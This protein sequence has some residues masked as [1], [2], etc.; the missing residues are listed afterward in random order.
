MNTNSQKLYIKNNKI[1]HKNV[2][3]QKKFF[4]FKKLTYTKSTSFHLSILKKPLKCVLLSWDF[5]NFQ[6][7]GKRILSKKFDTFKLPKRRI[8]R[9]KFCFSKQNMTQKL[10]YVN[11]VK[12]CLIR[13]N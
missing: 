12:K 9:T 11:R 4:L 5:N 10:S 6:K 3:Q 1:A 2:C 8:F 7:K 13:S